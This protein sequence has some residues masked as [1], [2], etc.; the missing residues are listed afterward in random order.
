METLICPEKVPGEPYLTGKN[1]R[2]LRPHVSFLN[3]SLGAG[4][5]RLRAARPGEP[6][7]FRRTIIYQVGAST[8]SKEF[9]G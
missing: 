9:V 8:K 3:R 7:A 6:R 4:T 2:K 1:T 5:R